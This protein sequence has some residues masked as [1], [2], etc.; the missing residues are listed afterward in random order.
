VRIDEAGFTLIEM[1][2]VLAV[3]ALVV[4][5]SFPALAH[6]QARQG[7]RQAEARLETELRQ[8]RARAIARDEQVRFAPSPAL[9]DRGRI[10]L[11]AGGLIFYRDGSSSGAHVALQAEGATISLA[12]DPVNGRIGRAPAPGR[13]GR[14]M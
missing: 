4:G 2:V 3:T 1:L 8:T 13:I 12:I 10:E 11:P 5:L 6:L 7:L 14:T 9:L